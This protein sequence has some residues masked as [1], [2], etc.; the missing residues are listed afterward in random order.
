MKKANRKTVNIWNNYYSTF[1]KN[2]KWLGNEYPNE[3]LVRFISNQ[4]K[5]YKKESYFLDKYQGH[6]IKNN[7]K[8]KALEIGFG[9]LANLL[10]LKKKGYDCTGIEV[11]KFAVKFANKFIKK[12][13]IKGIKTLEC[14]NLANLP[15]ENNSFDLIIGLQCI[16]YN[17]NIDEVLT[18]IKR[19]LK[20]NGI[21]IF[22]FFSQKHDYI[23]YT[24]TIDK[25]KNILAWAKNHPNKRIVGST[26][27]MPKNKKMLLKKF[28]IFSYNKIFTY[29]FDQLP[30]FQSWWYVSGKK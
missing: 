9:T 1:D 6:L 16:Y 10:M 20:K 21:Y 22:S 28:N 2:N 7:F 25:K 4:R 19:V 13:Q 3:P 12:N 14:K 15:F 26:F 24:T 8:G 29:E 5:N 17:T 18:E 11:S 23:K 27:F 30:L